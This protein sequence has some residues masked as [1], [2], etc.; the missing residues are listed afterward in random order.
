MRRGSAK[1]FST[2]SIIF[3]IFS[4][5]FN[6][7]SYTF[8]QVIIHNEEKIREI[9]RILEIKKTNLYNLNSSLNLSQ[10]LAYDFGH[11]ANKFLSILDFDTRAYGLFNNEETFRDN[12]KLD[13]K[14]LDATKY[15]KSYQ[16]KIIKNLNLYNQR[17]DNLYEV[18][19]TYFT[20][21]IT[22]ELLKDKEEYKNFIYK[23]YSKIPEE[24]IKEYFEKDTDRYESYSKFY[25]KISSLFDVS[26]DLREI[27]IF[28]QE[29]FSSSYVEYF[30]SLEKFSSDQNK[31]NYY[32][33]L[34]IVS[35]ILGL[36]FLL[37]LFR[38]LINEII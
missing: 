19:D 32:I 25:D 1:S 2:I 5:F 22:K 14:K 29:N 3:L 7:A 35:Q 38:N 27:Y 16:N 30:N 34:S 24:L 11:E 13:L 23:K 33:L 4:A 8:D 37:L 36:T 21:G 26:G 31:T 9:K 15:S 28:L 18:F 20:Y 10:D 17:I 12:F 6:L